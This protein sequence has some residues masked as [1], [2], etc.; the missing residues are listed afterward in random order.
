MRNTGGLRS[1]PE[2]RQ[3]HR[4]IA[5][6]QDPRRAP[7]SPARQLVETLLRDYEGPVAVELPDGELVARHASPACRLVFR[8]VDE[9]R[10]LVLRQDL[11]GLGE[12]FLTGGIDVVGDMESVFDLA[13]YLEGH[14]LMWRQRWRLLRLALQIPAAGRRSLPRRLRAGARLHRNQQ[15]S[16]AFHYDLSNEFYALWLDPEMVY[17]CAY[18]RDSEQSLA[19]A[20]RDKLDY[21]CRKLRLS[22]GQTLLDVGCGWGSLVCWAARH[23]GVAAR[24]ITL[25]EKQY[26]YAVERVRREG[27]EDRVSI[28]LRD[29]RDLPAGVQYDRIASVGMF[30]HVGVKNF[31]TYFGIVKRALKP[32][33][34][35]LNHGITNDRGWAP[36]ATTRFINRYVFPDGELTRI[37]V[38]TDAM[39]QAGFEILDVESLRRHY[40]L[41]LRHWVRSLEDRRKEAILAAG[42]EAAYRI[43]RLYMAGSA[44][45]FAQGTTN[46]YQVLA[47]HLLQ[48][49][50]LPLRRDDLYRP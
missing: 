7:R 41:T 13:D 46:I 42:D 8:R 31:P 16:I 14:P 1:A 12:A 6:P 18:F 27:L 2:Y 9:L 24:G 15:A 4:Q 37:S 3:G 39:E 19:A 26:R 45:Y 5:R 48:E 25:S 30:E 35:F 10:S 43:W 11:M 23:Y 20:Q 50:P 49:P 47:G 21:I 44:Y 32:G 33:G 28:E 17:S 38:V 29:Y 34:L 22:P 36:S 40:A